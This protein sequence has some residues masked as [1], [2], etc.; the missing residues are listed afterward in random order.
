MLSSLELNTLEQAQESPGQERVSRNL[1]KKQTGK[2]QA[3]LIMVSNRENTGKS[4][5]ELRTIQ[6]EQRRQGVYI[7]DS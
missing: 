7:L 3:G 1:S 6:Q 2:E 5:V 4:R